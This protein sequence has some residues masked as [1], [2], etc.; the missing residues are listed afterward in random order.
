M[1]ER[2]LGVT[3]IGILWILAALAWFALAL[4]GGAVLA[5]FGLGA[6]GAIVGVILFIIGVIDLLLGIGCFMGW[7]WVWTVGAIFMIINIL[8]GI[9][10]LF[11]NP[12]FG[13]VTIV[14]AVIV[15]WYLFQPQVKAFFG[16]P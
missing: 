3:V 8:F 15:L 16:K 9:V 5:V 14:I 12:V 13:L 2:P 4:I 10:V 7:G 11:A 6:L 1:A